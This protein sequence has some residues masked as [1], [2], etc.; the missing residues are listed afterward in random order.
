MTPL[1]S[2]L[3]RALTIDGRDYVLTLNPAALKL[4][5]KGKRNGVELSWTQ[6][7]NGEAALAVALHASLG[8]FAGKDKASVAAPTA[9]KAAPPAPN[10]EPPRPKAA[11]RPAAA[12]VPALK[13]KPSRKARPARKK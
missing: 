13:T 5:L 2:T 8:A 7:V 12:P 1:H 4:T 6:L 11:L 3:K 9:P 10:A